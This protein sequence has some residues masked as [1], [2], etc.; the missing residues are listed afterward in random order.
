[1]MSNQTSV[2]MPLPKTSL[3]EVQAPLNRLWA[4]LI[5]EELSRLGV[6]HVCVAPGSRST[7]LVL[8]AAEHQ[9]LT[10]HSHFDERGLGFFALGLAKSVQAPVAVIVTSGTAVANLLPAVVESGLTK[11]KLV[12]LTADRPLEQVNCGANQAIQQAGLFSSHVCHELL[13]P[14]PSLS[15]TPQWLLSNIDQSLAVQQQAGGVVH[16]NCPYPE[17]IYGGDADFS[18][19]LAGVNNWQAQ[20]QSYL[21]I[22]SAGIN[23]LTASPSVALM[24]DKADADLAIPVTVPVTM[25]VINRKGLVVIGAMNTADM[26]A[27]KQWADVMGWP[28]LVDPQSGGCSAWSH[29]D[30]WL[31][32]QACWNKL[33]E[34]EILVQFGA[35]LVS[36]RLG[37]FI[38]QHDWQDYWLIAPQAGQLDPYHQRCKQFVSSI[39]HW[40][41]QFASGQ[42]NAALSTNN[43]T[44]SNMITDLGVRH[45]DVNGYEWA[46]VLTV[47]SVTV[48]QLI[49]VNHIDALTEISFAATLDT[50]LSTTQANKST[51]LFIGNSL[52][53]RLLDMFTAL[54]NVP[55]FSNRGASGIDGLLAT[56]AGVQQ[57]QQQGMLCLLGDTSLL[58]DLN[59]LALFSKPTH[60][61]VIVVL[62]NDGGA[63]FDML[64]VSAQQKEQLYRMPHGF[65]FN[66]AAAMFDLDY[67]QPNSLADALS[68]IHHRLYPMADVTGDMRTLLVEI[69][70]P[71]G[72]AAKQLKQF[73][74]EVKDAK[75]I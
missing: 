6:R 24:S 39:P 46:R 42:L 28:V 58:Y 73:F 75:F 38:E 49:E 19:Y 37:Q 67:V 4:G 32:N 8:A 64:A 59:S 7:P 48:R 69:V 33:A 14:S 50:C 47:A 15:I 30:V 9:G 29:Y 3:A 20:Q 21:S 11:E 27:I 60:P 61:S 12:L 41:T 63:I 40:L 43:S 74:S 26:Q 36:K 51:S 18:D 70:T 13:L 52:I 17:P 68:V 65:N 44:L 66:H 62:N 57:G 1:M 16:I 53:V 45:S 25:P 2:D 22:Y 10:L 56:A 55:V 23:Y 71:A 35:R 54:P 5:L 31:Q 72:A 34:A